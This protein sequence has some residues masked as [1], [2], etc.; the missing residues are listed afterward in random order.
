MRFWPLAVGTIIC[1]VAAASAQTMPSDAAAATPA[2]KML[3][4]MLRLSPAA[5][6]PAGSEKSA[7]ATQPAEAPALRPGGYAAP[8]PSPNL[9]REGCEVVARTGYL[10]KIPDSVYPQLVFTDNSAANY[11]APMLVLP[12]LQLMSMEDATAQMSDR[13]TFTVSGTVMEYKGKNYLLLAPGP[14][15]VKRQIPPPVLTVDAHGPVSAEQMLNEMLSAQSR[16]PAV[17]PM[18]PPQTDAAS[19]AGALPPQAPVLSVL[20]ER[21]QIFDRVCRLSRSADGAQEELTLESDGTALRD[22]PLIVLPNLKLLA[23]EGAANNDL[24]ARFRV[25][26]VVS[27]Y[28]GRN[29][30]LL[31]KVVVMADSDRQF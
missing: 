20:P 15:E 28:R 23:L 19:G 4:E 21:S 17:P 10:R 2:E 8:G 1:C 14:E 30:I 7:P 29:Y 16:P 12:N 5:T 6:V 11:L 27:E 26:G 3:S 18:P 24:N 31:Q 13:H 25:A 9:L 22:P